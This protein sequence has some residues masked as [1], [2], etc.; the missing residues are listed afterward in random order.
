MIGWCYKTFQF[1]F[2][3]NKFILGSFRSRMRA[4]HPTR[5]KK[6][7]KKKYR[8]KST[9]SKK[10]EKKSAGKKSKP[11]QDLFRSRDVV[12]SGVKGPTRA[13]IAQLRVAHVQNI[14]PNRTSSGHFRS[15]HF[16]SLLVT[17][18]QA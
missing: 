14:L 6:Y 10:Y 16:L 8:K 17:S 5:E 11:G 12:N 18:G 13:D 7:G 2:R 9:G 4:P 3:L 1:S 15:R